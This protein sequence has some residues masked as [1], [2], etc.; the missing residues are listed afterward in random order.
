MVQQAK[1]G[2]VKLS[3]AMLVKNSGKS[4]PTVLKSISR[5]ADEI[6]VLDTGSDDNTREVAESFGAKVFEYS[7][8]TPPGVWI[9]DF[10]HARQESFDHCTNE[11]VFWIDSDDELLGAEQLKEMCKE[12]D[13][14]SRLGCIALLY[15]Y[16]FDS[17]GNPITTHWRER[18]V[19]KSWF[20]WAARV[21]ENLVQVRES[22]SK[23][24]HEAVVIHKKSAE[25]HA[26]A[27]D[28][29][30]AILLKA[31]EDEGKTP[32][33]RTL[34]GMAQALRGAQKYEE[35]NGFYKHYLELSGWDEEK[36]VARCSVVSNYLQL[37]DLAS[38]YDETWETIKAMPDRSEAYFY[39]AR[40]AFLR[41]QWAE[42]IRWSEEGFRKGHKE[43]MTIWNPR[44]YDLNPLYF[45]TAAFFHTAQYQ[46]CLAAVDKILELTPN[47]QQYVEMR[48][49]CQE[50]IRELELI[51]SMKYVERWLKDKGEDEKLPILAHCQPKGF[52]LPS[53]EVYKG[54]GPEVAKRISIYCPASVEFWSPASE[55][56]GIGGSEE[57]VI[58][59]ARGLRDN[60][61]N[62]TVYNLCTTEDDR[63]WD[64]VRYTDFTTCM[65]QDKPDVFIYWRNPGSVENGFQGH[66]THIWLHDLQKSEYW[67]GDRLKRIDKAMVLSEYHRHNV[68]FIPDD[69][70]WITRNGIN[71]EHFDQLVDRN[72]NKLI[73]TSSP[74]RGLEILMQIWEEL[75]RRHPEVELDVFYGWNKTFDALYAGNKGMQQWKSLMMKSL[76]RPG[77]NYKGRVGHKEIATAMMGSNL[78]TYPSGFCEI[79][80]I[81]AMKAQAAGS[82]PVVTKLAALNETVQ[83]GWK[84]ES[85]VFEIDIHKKQDEYLNLLDHALKQNLE[86]E[87]IRKEMVPW[88]LKKFS[89][90]TVSKEWSDVFAGGKVIA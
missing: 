5:I 40:I 54:R 67:F 62:V 72:P 18:I 52:R 37:K 56:S 49:A 23:K 84:L 36:Y 43:G 88:A 61:W 9:D 57:A 8:K 7:R 77:I 44:D 58:N 87:R 39:L 69:K 13:E 83:H 55:V 30:I 19:R 2:R 20:K 21:H 31:L 6:V 38:A 53:L 26:K 42:V 89:W 33:P 66:Q 78:F 15:H 41:N 28:R 79:S 74:D 59:M 85:D 60:G 4:L 75:R 10:G 81:S 27:N 1:G 80:C 17:H 14:D 32:D 63:D 46:K 12:F 48:K 22:Y 3:V 76:E 64:G 47:D 35:S 50:Y 68:A 25:D 70:I 11:L 51:R 65:K 45:L 82:I 29:N 73:Y 16:A 24:F 34:F 90:A 71:P 86:N